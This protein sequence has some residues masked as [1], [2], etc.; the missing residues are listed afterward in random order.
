MKTH[1]DKEHTSKDCQ[2]NY[3]VEKLKLRYYYIPI[4]TNKIRNDAI[5]CW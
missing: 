3:P 5:K 1:F 4:R 2:H